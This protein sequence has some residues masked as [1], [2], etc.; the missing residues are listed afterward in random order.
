MENLGLVRFTIRRMGLSLRPNE[1]MSDIWSTGVIGLIK[2]VDGFD[3]NYGTAFSSYAVPS[4]KFEI[5][6]EL[7]RT[8]K[9]RS[10]TPTDEEWLLDGCDHSV[11]VREEASIKADDSSMLGI[12]SELPD[13]EA[14]VIRRIYWENSTLREIGSDMGISHSRIEQIHAVAIQRLRKRFSEVDGGPS[15][16]SHFEEVRGMQV[17]D[18]CDVPVK[19]PRGGDRKVCGKCKIPIEERVHSGGGPTGGA[20]DR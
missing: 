15:S 16:G 18:C 17:S 3:R 12:V 9:M 13:R 5:L 7:R 10:E 14:E 2:A 8:S 6:R 4:I 11:G 1:E 20:A 19:I